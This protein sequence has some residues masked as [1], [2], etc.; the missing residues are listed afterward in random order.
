MLAKFKPTLLHCFSTMD[1]MV[2]TTPD[3]RVRE[4][5]EQ[6]HT[7][8]LQRVTRILVGELEENAK[9]VQPKE[10]EPAN[11]LDVSNSAATTL[12]EGAVP[13]RESQIC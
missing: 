13:V 3:T 8:A 10:P 4:D 7:S 12:V 2:K 9:P 11:L 6:S 5:H 1:P